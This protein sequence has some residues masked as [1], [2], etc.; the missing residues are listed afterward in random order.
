LN[1]ES[2]HFEPNEVPSAPQFTELR[3]ILEEHPAE[4]MLWE[5]EP[6][7][8]AVVFLEELGISSIVF[9]PCSN[10]PETSDFLTVMR[11][12]VENPGGIAAPAKQE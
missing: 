2:V 4:W 5:G 7:E 11:E 12:N 3:D 1:L 10:T 8:E 9:D 6:M